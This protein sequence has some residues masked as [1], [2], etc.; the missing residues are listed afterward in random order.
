MVIE[1]VKSHCCMRVFKGQWTCAGTDRSESSIPSGYY[2]TTLFNAL[3][4]IETTLYES[5][6][7]NY[8][9]IL[10][11]FIIKFKKFESKV[12]LK[13]LSIGIN[14]IFLRLKGRYIEEE[15]RRGRDGTP[16]RDILSVLDSQSVCPRV[17]P[18]S[19]AGRNRHSTDS[20]ARPFFS[21]LYLSRS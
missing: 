8:F 11:H 7:N 21:I 16:T 12:A 13:Q 10:S 17:T 4:H 2:S 9:K 3:L 15:T 1:R 6:G 19:A 20:R 18:K 14:F 5:K